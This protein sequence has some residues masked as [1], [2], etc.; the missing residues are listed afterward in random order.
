MKK[1]PTD[2]H[3]EG[4]YLEQ[5]RERRR[6]LV[7]VTGCPRCLERIA[8][9]RRRAAERATPDSEEPDRGGREPGP[10][11]LA[12]PF[13]LILRRERRRARAVPRPAAAAAGAQGGLRPL[14]RPAPHLGLLRAAGRAQPGDRDARPRARR[15]AV[16]RA[17]P[18]RGVEAAGG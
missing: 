16:R 12:G 17:E 18:D 1:H 9:I 11:D 3:L 4:L 8:E 2:L 15:G 10:D 14:R 5:D 6:M 7:H 13:V